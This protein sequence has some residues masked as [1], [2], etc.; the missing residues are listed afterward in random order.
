MFGKLMSTSDDLMD[1]YYQLLLGET[2]DEN[3][4]PMEAKKQLAH[5]LTTR[6]HDEAA[7][8]DARKTWEA[9]FSKRDD[10]AGAIELTLAD[11]PDGGTVIQLASHAYQAGFQLT[12]SNGELK[13]Q[14]IL[15]GAVQL[16]GEKLTDPNATP[17]LKVGD[18]LRLSKKHS[19]KIG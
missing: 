1:R 15:P 16:N 6:Y 8:I 10:S 18:I 5:K 17:E 19:V 14:S 4:H 2:R 7:A 13:K 12:K 3:L 9:R 11:F